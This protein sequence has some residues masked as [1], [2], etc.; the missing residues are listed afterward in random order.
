MKNCKTCVHNKI[1]I[2][3]NSGSEASICEQY[4]EKVECVYVI[5]VLS[6]YQWFTL[7]KVFINIY[8]AQDYIKSLPDEPKQVTDTFFY[9]KTKKYNIKV[10][11]IEV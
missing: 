11:E 1:C 8:K 2:F 9:S 5:N 3:N 7:S 10:Y 6:T 4:S